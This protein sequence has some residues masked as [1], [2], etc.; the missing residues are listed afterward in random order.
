MNLYETTFNIKE[1]PLHS[2]RKTSAL[3]AVKKQK[4]AK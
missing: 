2:L 3:S 4:N 1:K